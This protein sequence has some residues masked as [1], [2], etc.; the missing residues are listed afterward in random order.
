MGTKRFDSVG[1]YA[2][3]REPIPLRCR[4][5]W[6]YGEVDPVPLILRFGSGRPPELV[7][8]RC[9]A[10]GS[11]SGFLL[12]SAARIPDERLRRPK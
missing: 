4:A 6:H 2:R 10:C 5:C 12:A 8:W 7:P 1:D 11:R 9:S 3:H